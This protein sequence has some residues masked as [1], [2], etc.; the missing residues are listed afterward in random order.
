MTE[1]DVHEMWTQLTVTHA[2]TQP[3]DLERESRPGFWSLVGERYHGTNVPALV[4]Q[5][6]ASDPGVSGSGEMSGAKPTSR[7]TARI[8]ALDTV[9]LIDDEAGDWIDRLGGEVPADAI[10]PRTLLT[11]PGVGTVRR[12]Q[13]LHG[14]HPSTE[15]CGRPKH[16][17]DDEKLWCCPRGELEHD[18]ERWWHQ[19]RI[20]AGWDLAPFTPH[21]TC[22]AC[23]VLGKLRI[24]YVGDP[25]LDSAMCV[26][27]RVTWPADR[28]GLLVEHIRA[29][30]MEEGEPDDTR[31]EECA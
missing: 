2:H 12:L 6:V 8:E 13:R 27:C 11:I 31:T 16:R 25:E 23:D 4:M 7:P 29:E 22:P 21:N 9:T 1:I 26:S 5:L 20:V 18:V 24:R 17:K 10:N 14:L 15:D 30:N 28:M 3:Y 19:A